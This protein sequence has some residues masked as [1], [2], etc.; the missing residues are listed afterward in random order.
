L[1][2]DLAIDY[3][4]SCPP[5]AVLFSFEDNDTYPI[6]YAQEVEGVRPDVRVIIN[7]LSG[8]DW[9]MNQ[10]RY[11]VNNSG[12]LD[13]IFSPEQIMGDKKSIAYFDQA[14]AGYNKNDYYDLYDTFKTVLAN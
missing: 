4:E 1:A 5:N 2:R 6:W 14:A 8:T 9:L 13:I 3:L 12:P 11:K 7:T 10:L